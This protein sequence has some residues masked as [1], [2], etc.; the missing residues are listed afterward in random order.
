MSIRGSVSC[1]RTRNL[2]PGTSG[3]A[4]SVMLSAKA[5]MPS[6]I[7]CTIL[8]TVHNLSRPIL[9]KASKVARETRSLPSHYEGESRCAPSKVKMAVSEDH[10][11]TGKAYNVLVRLALPPY[12]IHFKSSTYM[13]ETTMEMLDK[14]VCKESLRATAQKAEVRWEIL[15]TFCAGCG[16]RC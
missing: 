15:H 1:P 10:S 8:Y 11:K 13:K 16:I 6:N 2:R 3:G 14:T 9:Y 5:H 12:T 4:V 7:T